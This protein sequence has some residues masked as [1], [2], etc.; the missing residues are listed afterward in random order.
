MIDLF[1]IG[2]LKMKVGGNM[3]IKEIYPILIITLTMSLIISFC[4]SQE[5]AIYAFAGIFAEEPAQI[6]DSAGDEKTRETAARITKAKL[7]LI[8]SQHHNEDKG[9]EVLKEPEA[10]S[11]SG[12]R[13]S[14]AMDMV[15]TA[16]DLSYESC[17]KYPDHPEY[18]IT[19]SGTKAEP[20]TVAV[21]PDVIPLGTKLYIASTDGSPDYGFATALDIGS[22]IKGYR[23]DLFMEDKQDA[24]NFGRRQV[25]V[26]ILD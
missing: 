5:K 8:E 25:K 17:G 9:E 15:A 21:D 16:Y 4:F 18:G 10:V 24:M 2:Q 1:R 11:R 6:D 22:A 20:G 19:A 7:T 26:Y 14:Q 12:F 23:I 13:F 3:K